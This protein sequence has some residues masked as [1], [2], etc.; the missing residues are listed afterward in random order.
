LLARCRTVGPLRG[1]IEVVAGQQAADGS[2]MGRS[3]GRNA[4]GNV[5]AERHPARRRRTDRTT[6]TDDALVTRR[7]KSEL[8]SRQSTVFSP[9]PTTR[10]A[11]PQRDSWHCRPPAVTLVT[12]RPKKPT[13]DAAASG[14]SIRGT[15]RGAR[16]E[17]SRR[18]RSL[19]IGIERARGATCLG[20]AD[21]AAAEHTVS[22]EFRPWRPRSERA[23]GVR[24]LARLVR[25]PGV[26]EAPLQVRP[27]SPC[28]VRVMRP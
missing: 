27:R 22:V 1:L 24:S 26:D 23:V 9:L 7:R 28:Q 15:P 14:H 25:R 19:S 16:E 17:Y 20:S 12:G 13:A 5:L 21:D 8:S 4:W 2:V 3:R 6:S 11:K 10:A 18:G